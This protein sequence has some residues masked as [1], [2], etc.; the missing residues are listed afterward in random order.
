MVPVVPTTVKISLTLA[1]QIFVTDEV[2]SEGAHAHYADWFTRNFGVDGSA[3]LSKLSLSILTQVIEPLSLFHKCLSYTRILIEQALT[4]L[5]PEASKGCLLLWL[6]ALRA[7]RQHSRAKYKQRAKK[8][9]KGLRPPATHVAEAADQCQDDQIA[10]FIGLVQAQLSVLSAREGE[11]GQNLACTSSIPSV[12]STLIRRTENTRTQAH[13]YTQSAA[14]Q[15]LN[16]SFLTDT[17]AVRTARELLTEFEASTPRVPARVKRLHQFKRVWWNTAVVPNLFH[18]RRGLCR[19]DDGGVVDLSAPTDQACKDFV[20][21]LE[22]QQFLGPAACAVLRK[23]R[24]DEMER[25]VGTSAF[26]TPGPALGSCEMSELAE[27]AQHTFGQLPRLLR[28]STQYPPPGWTRFRVK[29]SALSRKLH[30]QVVTQANH[31]FQPSSC[32][33][34]HIAQSNGMRRRPWR[35]RLAYYLSMPMDKRCR[36]QVCAGDQLFPLSI[37]LHLQV[38]PSLQRTCGCPTFGAP[39]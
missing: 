26:R 17:E 39:C 29:L 35:W 32:N 4:E 7:H 33:S 11:N 2:S 8:K 25:A 1:G 37:L 31:A 5:V 9:G 23:E 10:D 12:W 19:H 13:A 3:L 15:F 16:G 6:R 18:L 14:Q 24:Q 36:D 22:R 21:L 28:S 20:Q 30:F 34:M 38:L 27:T